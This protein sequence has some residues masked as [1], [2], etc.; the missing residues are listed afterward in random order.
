MLI[1]RNGLKPSANMGDW[2]GMASAKILSLFIN[3]LFIFA[4]YTIPKLDKKE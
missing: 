3:S 4:C 2:H 1:G